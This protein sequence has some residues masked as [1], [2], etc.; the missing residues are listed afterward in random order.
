MISSPL[1]VAAA[2]PTSLSASSPPPIIGESP[3]RPSV[4]H[5]CPPGVHPAPPQ[6]S[7]PPHSGDP[8]N[9]SAAMAGPPHNSYTQLHDAVRVRQPAISDRV[10]LRIKLDCVRGLLDRIQ[11]AS[12][13]RKDSPADL[14]GLL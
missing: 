6:R 11:R 4:L 14:A 13:L 5:P 8:G 10:H 12:L 3:P 9:R 2:A 1:P 7:A